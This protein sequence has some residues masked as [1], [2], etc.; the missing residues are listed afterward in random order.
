MER[1]RHHNFGTASN[2]IYGIGCIDQIGLAVVRSNAR[3]PVLLT[4]RGV[5]AA[6]IV[7]GP[8][9]TITSLGIPLEVFPDVTPEPTLDSVER[10]HQKLENRNFDM[11]IGIGGGSTL[12]VTKLLSVMLTNRMPL[13]AMVGVDKIEAP[14]IPTLLVP[15]TAGTGSEATPNAI[16]AQEDLGLKTGVVSRY[17]LPS[18]AILDPHMTVGLPPA[19]TASTGMDAFIHSLESYTG[20]MANPLSDAFAMRSISLIL[21]SLTKAFL[22]GTDVG[23]RYDML[24]GSTLGG[25]ALSC[26]GTAA[27]HALSYPLGAKYRIPHGVANSMLLL[28]VLKYNLGFISDRMADI[29][30]LIAGD[31]ILDFDPGLSTDGKVEAVLD[32][33]QGLL[34]ELRIPARLR[35]FGVKASDLDTISEAALRVQRLIQNNPKEIGFGA[36]K[37]IYTGLL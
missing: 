27:V 5:Y 35:D 17:L 3:Q 13:Q 10:L 37:E 22:D 15:T 29:Y 21:K 2:T 23:A 26:S 8:A 33:L 25:M 14:G 30:D 11:L 6:G 32:Y 7:Q 34:R 16:I 19:L 12:D 18:L 20:R 4:D 36:I 24:I 1:S 9:E 28:P 31:K